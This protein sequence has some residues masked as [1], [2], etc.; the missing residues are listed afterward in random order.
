LPISPAGSRPALPGTDAPCSAARHAAAEHA[1]DLRALKDAHAATLTAVVGAL[2]SRR[3]S[4]AAAREV[5]LAIASSALTGLRGELT[6]GEARQALAVVP[7]EP[8]AAGCV[9]VLAQA[10]DTAT[11]RGVARG[12]LE[13]LSVRE[14]DVLT[15]LARGRSNRGIAARLHISE[16]TV[17]FHVAN[18]LAKLGV[19]SRGEA[20]AAARAAHL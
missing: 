18:I 19:R 13:A 4:D 11:A 10:P 12:P 20:A 3:L 6:A 17:K 5:A 14:L 8:A 9:L 2:R 7:G 16:H 15:E 1:R